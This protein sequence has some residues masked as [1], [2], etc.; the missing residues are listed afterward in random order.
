MNC[1]LC[2]AKIMSPDHNMRFASPLPISIYK[3]LLVNATKGEPAMV[4]DTVGVTTKQG[5]P[6]CVVLVCSKCRDE[7]GE[8]DVTDNKS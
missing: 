7:F 8:Y 3:G 2:G 1:E 5:Q 6:Y 4:L